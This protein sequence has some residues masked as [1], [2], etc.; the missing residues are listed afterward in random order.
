[1][2]ATARAQAHGGTETIL[3]AED[4]ASVR[5]FVREVLTGAGYHVLDG[6]APTDA[7]AL[8]AAHP[9]PI[10]LLLSDVVMPQLSGPELA[11]RLH[12][13]RPGVPVLFMSGYPGDRLAGER[14][15][16]LTKPVR[17]SD[18]LDAIRETLDAARPA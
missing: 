7:L 5:E 16:V 2:A 18:L 12:A 1:M 4:E 13:S 3:L 15:R 6:G 8:A 10:H 17:P 11:S 9:G 14:G